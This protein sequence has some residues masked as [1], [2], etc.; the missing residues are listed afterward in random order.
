MLFLRLYKIH[1]LLFCF[2][3]QDN[4]YP[5]YCKSYKKCQSLKSRD[6]IFESYYKR[7]SISKEENYYTMKW[8]KKKDLF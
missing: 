3:I 8:L 2:P 7:I 4:L 5:K 1:F 6:F